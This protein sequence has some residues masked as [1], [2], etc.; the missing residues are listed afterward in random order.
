MARE[1]D[2]VSIEVLFGLAR[3]RLARWEMDKALEMFARIRQVDPAS[4][5][6]FGYVSDIYMKT[7][8]MVQGSTD[9]A[10]QLESMRALESAGEIPLPP[11]DDAR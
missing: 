8:D 4:V 6:G 9:M 10:R 11:V 7:G 2:P 3:I 5:S 1:L